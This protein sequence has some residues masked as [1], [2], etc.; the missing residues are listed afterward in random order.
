MGYL[1]FSITKG[2]RKCTRLWISMVSLIE[3]HISNTTILQHVGMF[4]NK[5]FSDTGYTVFT[6]DAVIRSGSD[7]TLVRCAV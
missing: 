6:H 1:I 2:E 5:F 7:G 4:K 3:M